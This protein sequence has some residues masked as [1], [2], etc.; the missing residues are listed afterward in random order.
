MCEKC[1]GK[2]KCAKCGAAAKT[3]QMANAWKKADV[4]IQQQAA[5]KRRRRRKATT[6]AAPSAR[7]SFAAE[8]R[9]RNVHVKGGA[10]KGLWS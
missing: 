7:G 3:K 5:P 8:Q 4:M 2:K 6:T 1:K 10:S 9:M